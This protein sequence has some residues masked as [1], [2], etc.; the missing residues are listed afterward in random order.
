MPNKTKLEI[1]NKV[2]NTQVKLKYIIITIILIIL[3]LIISGN[4]SYAEECTVG[5]VTFAYNLVNGKAENVYVSAYQGNKPN[6]NTFKGLILEIPSSLDGHDV[7]SI[8]DGVNTILGLERSDAIPK[9]FR[10]STK[11]QQQFGKIILPNTLKTI[12]SYAMYCSTL[13]EIITI[14]NGVRNIEDFAFANIHYD[15]F[16]KY[17]V[18]IPNSVET[19]G[20]YAFSNFFGDAHYMHVGYMA[21]GSASSNMGRWWNAPNPRGFTSLKLGSGLKSIGKYAF[22]NQCYINALTIPDNVTDIGEGAFSRT[23]ISQLNIQDRATTLNIGDWCFSESLINHNMVIKDE[24]NMGA[25]VFASCSNLPSVEFENTITTIP[26]GICSDCEKLADVI[27]TRIT[28]IGKDAFMKCP[29]I[30]TEEY[31]DIVRDATNIG[32]YAFRECSGITGTIE[33]PSCV[34]TMGKGVFREC[35]N[36]ENVT[37]STPI[38]DLPA[39]TFMDCMSLITDAYYNITEK[40]TSIGDYAFSGCSALTGKITIDN[41][42]TYLGNY[43]FSRCSR[44]EETEINAQ[45][46]KLLDGVYKDCGMLSKVSKPNSVTEIG[47]E[48]FENCTSISSEI[49]HNNILTNITSI[50]NKA[51]KNCKG[52]EGTL[53]INDIVTKVGDSAYEDCTNVSKIV[54]Q[55][56]TTNKAIGAK[57]FYNAAANQE[58]VRLY[59]NPSNSNKTTI[60]SKAFTNIKEM[61][62]GEKRD[63]TSFDYRYYGN[64][65][66]IPI[67]HYYDCTHFV[68]V[69]CTLP[70]VKLVNPETNEELTSNNIECESSYSFKLVIE[71]E[72][73]DKYKDLAIKLVSEG[74]YSDSDQVEEFITLDANN[75]YTID[76]VTRNKKIIVQKTK[77]GTDLVLREFISKVNGDDLR[78]KRIARA[79]KAEDAVDTF[80]YNHTKYPL[81]LKLGDKVTYTIRVYNEGNV[82]GS[83]NKI[84][85][86]LSEGLTYTDVGS[87]SGWVVSEDGRTI[88][89]EYLKDKKIEKYSGAGR[90]EYEELTFVCEITGQSEDDKYMVAL[91]EIAEGNDLDSL[92]N[93]TVNTDLTTFM[94]EE[95]YL[96]S[97]DTYTKCIED[98]TDFEGIE[99]KGKVRVGYNLVVNKIDSSSNELLNGAKIRLLDENKNEI[100][101]ILTQDGKADFGEITSYGEGTDTYYIEEVETPVGY[102]RTIDGM[103]ELQVIKTIDETGATSVEIVCDLQNKKEDAE[104]FK[105]DVDE[106][107]EFIPIT[108]AEQLQKIGSN[109]NVIVNGKT[110]RFL[111]SSNYILQNDITLESFTP[112]SFM[113]G[114]FDGNGKTISGL[115][116]NDGEA[117]YAETGMFRVFRGEI[118]NLKITDIQV[119]GTG[120][121]EP[122]NID[123][124]CIYIGD[125]RSAVGAL[126]GYMMYGTIKNCSIENGSIKSSHDNLGGFVGHTSYA[127]KFDE[128]TIED[129]VNISIISDMKNQKNNLG[130]FVGCVLS[131]AIINNSTNKA[132]VGD[133]EHYTNNVGGFVG[134]IHSGGKISAENLTSDSSSII[135]VSNIGGIVG[136]I[137]EEATANICDCQ[138]NAK[139]TQIGWADDKSYTII[140]GS[141]IT[142]FRETHIG[143]NAGGIVGFSEGATNIVNCSNTASISSYGYNVG[144]IIGHSEPKGDFKQNVSVNYNSENQ[145]IEL[146][147]KNKHTQ[148]NYSLQIQKADLT[149][150]KTLS[151]AH[152]NVYNS[153]L[154]LIKEDEEV[155]EKGVL[156]IDNINIDSIVPDVYY[157]KETKA[158]DG[159]EILVK[160]YVKVEVN[161]KWDGVNEK[162]LIDTK[163]VIEVDKNLEKIEQEDDNT[164]TGK[165]IGT[166]TCENVKYKSRKTS[167]TDCNNSGDIVKKELSSS[168]NID[169]ANYG[170]I[171]GVIE[172][173]NLIQNCHNTAKAIE[174]KREAGGIVGQLMLYDYED[175]SIVR[176]CTNSSPVK[177]GTV[178]GIIGYNTMPVKVYDC[179]NEK[180]AIVEGID[181]YEENAGGIIGGSRADTYVENCEN[182]AQVTGKYIGGIIGCNMGTFCVYNLSGRHV[183]NEY[184]QIINCIVKDCSI[185][186]NSTSCKRESAGGILGVSCTPKIKI[187]D[188]HVENVTIYSVKDS[189]GIIGTY[190]GE[191]IRINNSN[192]ISSRI[193]DSDGSQAGGILGGEHFYVY[194]NGDD[195]YQNQTD[196]K[197]NGCNVLGCTISSN[198]AGGISGALNSHWPVST[199]LDVKNCNVGMDNQGNKSVII[200]RKQSAGILAGLYGGDGRTAEYKINIEESDVDSAIIQAGTNVSEAGCAG[201]IGFSQTYMYPIDININKCNVT[202]CML[203]GGNEKGAGYASGILGQMYAAN[204]GDAYSTLNI[205]DCNVIGTDIKSSATN[206]GGISGYLYQ[207]RDVSFNNCKV[208]N[209]DITRSRKDKIVY[210]DNIGGFIAGAYGADR[211][212]KFNNCAASGINIDAP[213]KNLS[214]FMGSGY[215]CDISMKDIKVIPYINPNTKVEEKNS[216]VIYPE[217]EPYQKYSCGG[218]VGMTMSD[219]G[220]RGAGKGDEKRNISFE[221]IE[222]SDI[223]V[224]PNSEDTMTSYDYNFGGLYGFQGDAENVN[225]SNIKVKNIDY[226]VKRNYTKDNYSFGSCAG[227][228][229]TTYGK[230]STDISNIEIEN[231][232]INSNRGKA[233]GFIGCVMCNRD[234]VV[235][236]DNIDINDVIIN[237]DNDEGNNVSGFIGVNYTYN[238]ISNIGNININNVDLNMHNSSQSQI[239][240]YNN[241]STM[242]GLI[243]W[244]YATNQE[245]KDV[246]IN[247][248]N[249]IATVAETRTDALKVVNMAGIIA[250]NGNTEKQEV[251]IDG[252]EINNIL[253][254]TDSERGC[255]GGIHGVQV[256]S[257]NVSISNSQVNNITA[258]G[259]YAVG[260]IVGIGDV[261][262]NNCTVTNPILTGEEGIATNGWTTEISGVTT[263]TIGGAV[264]IAVEGANLDNITVTADLP[265][266]QAEPS[267]YG[268]FSDYIAA[269]IVGI[270]S[271]K[272]SNS[273]VENIVV[274][275]T[276]ETLNFTEE[277][278][279]GRDEVIAIGGVSGAHAREIQVLSLQD[280]IDCIATNVKVICGNKE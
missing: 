268:I 213:A 259:Q 184:T 103:A 202:S 21:L 200:A 210:T 261:D 67:V 190:S 276:R 54:F 139:I 234:T 131:D 269:G 56:G 211:V 118:R 145:T 1:D 214:T 113:N 212:L 50:G 59:G 82:D 274:K 45:I 84:A 240:G 109:E 148:G 68:D 273:K 80:N 182:Y 183:E 89:T 71:D 115:H 227:F 132:I 177:G 250:V 64:S 270:N 225:F 155:D 116:I 166:I 265:E 143:N 62:I 6:K 34:T 192:V 61:F 164:N 162:Y 69:I 108:T 95:A 46:D 91:A 260:G 204:Y 217:T 76:S 266:G 156:K 126:V 100:K 251:T 11:E 256:R 245:I 218:L 120:K 135:G 19:I 138:N 85:V 13:D 127:V 249:M 151:G 272:I 55:E 106:T 29:S 97:S 78:E 163:P 58:I 279:D 102:K 87:T 86:R 153:N 65:I 146:Y 193:V 119:V 186:I 168:T 238:A 107:K 43:A 267:T 92:E 158:P 188:C 14:P 169:S 228:I 244:N 4:N 216:L 172:G 170:G 187:E 254:N 23:S 5:D 79:E 222:C 161:K 57:A 255:I 33:I 220:S 230:K 16:G 7:V 167:I 191:E 99:L 8:G 237:M 123:T 60:G 48:T 247:N 165:R 101:T 112:I 90:P 173:S 28:E 262:I 2:I 47:N 96:S 175:S 110:Y 105:A 215:L 243:G 51:F 38:T 150:N 137:A 208:E 128:C 206:I 224:R 271:G 37:M 198:Y 30:T 121:K 159:Y 199:Y 149:L 70:G 195:D 93:S 176:E 9:G 226:K 10:S 154:E 141:T 44:I 201:I 66:T 194:Y 242:S 12:N 174:S 122:S 229:G 252:V 136:Y 178:G 232:K 124:K 17:E 236:I 203:I 278:P 52:V 24:Y 140:E 104:D 239:N 142:G 205:S 264:G 130:G 73:K 25:Y 209:L 280:F 3:G 133:S 83:V 53:T 40:I 241:T 196:I 263:P 171:A 277:N 180:S 233:T 35:Y 179:V 147:M 77:N 94:R 275:S 75:T 246:N 74:Q 152:F 117:E 26:Q 235:N 49:L 125:N 36:I 223:I 257:A 181:S 157:I 197:L 81:I 20:N 185:G 253:M 160:D 129:S 144:G 248:I 15:Y 31:A 98:D 219:A 42:V 258:T 27:K 114:I 134:Y 18:V 189:G 72:Y 231:I 63:N 111:Q 207:V 41:K 32:E 221:N 22:A 39:E 88:T